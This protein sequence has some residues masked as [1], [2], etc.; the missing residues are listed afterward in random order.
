[1]DI[2]HSQLNVHVPEGWFA[3]ESMTLLTLDGQAN[4]IASIEPLD[5]YVDAKWYAHRQGELL[6]EEFPGY[7]EVAFSPTEWLGGRRGFARVFA[8]YP[9]DGERVTQIQLYYADNGKGYTATATASSQ[10]FERLELQLWEVLS[11]LALDSGR[12]GRE[13]ERRSDETPEGFSLSMI[14]KY[15]RTRGYPF[16]RDQNDLFTVRFTRDEASGRELTVWLS[17]EGQENNVYAIRVYADEP[18]AEADFHKALAACNTWNAKWRWARAVLL[19]Q[20]GPDAGAAGQIM[21]DWHLDLREGMHQELLSYVTDDAIRTAFEFWT[22]VRQ[23]E[24]FGDRPEDLPVAQEEPTVE[25]TSRRSW[26]RSE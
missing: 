16:L 9:S 25:E 7:Q 21:I 2:Y 1:M 4:V 10:S 8:W 22:W 11:G 23:E 3:K 18:V 15:L 14:E 13:P 20:D 5:P 6:Q 19:H 17:A 24:L 26:W 12:S